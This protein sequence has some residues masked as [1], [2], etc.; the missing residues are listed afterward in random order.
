MAASTSLSSDRLSA[1]RKD[2]QC[3]LDPVSATSIQSVPP[4]SSQCHLDPVSA[5]SI[6]QCH[7]DPVSATTIGQCHLDRSTS[8]NSSPSSTLSARSIARALS[9]EQFDRR[10]VQRWLTVEWPSPA[11]RAS[12][13]SLMPARSRQRT[14]TSLLRRRTAAIPCGRRPDAR[15]RRREASWAVAHRSAPRQGP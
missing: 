13:R 11:R 1:T 8:R 2:D 15:W 5:T 7:L 12:S 9:G 3:H 14:R 4:R 10:P 6:G